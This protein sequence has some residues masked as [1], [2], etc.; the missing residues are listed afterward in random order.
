MKTLPGHSHRLRD[1]LSKLT[2]Y[3]CWLDENVTFQIKRFV[4]NW[5][6]GS[7]A[8]WKYLNFR[9]MD[10]RPGKY[11]KTNIGPW[12]CLN[13]IWNKL[14]GAISKIVLYV[15]SKTEGNGTNEKNLA[16]CVSRSR[17]HSNIV[18]NF[19]AVNMQGIEITFEWVFAITHTLCK[20]STSYSA[21]IIIRHVDILITFFFL[22]AHFTN[23]KPHQS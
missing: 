23:S 4:N 11:L 14:Y 21:C 10:S 3:E 9:H 2:I 15:L 5:T 13:Y 16:Q 19:R 6:Q 20:V 17:K 8:S 12:K 22:Q 1:I 18:Y 7:H